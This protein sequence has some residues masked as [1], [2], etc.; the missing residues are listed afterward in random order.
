MVRIQIKLPDGVVKV[1][2][3]TMTMTLLELL[4]SVGAPAEGVIVFNDGDTP[5]TDL[6]KTMVDYNNWCVEKDFIG[7]IYLMWLKDALSSRLDD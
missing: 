2:T 6:S 3:V 1:A 5:M 7:S 4:Q